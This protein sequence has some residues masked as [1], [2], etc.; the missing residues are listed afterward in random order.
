[1]NVCH[2]IC[3][4]STSN[5]CLKFASIFVLI[6]KAHESFCH[7]LVL[8][9]LCADLLM[10]HVFQENSKPPL[11][12]ELICINLYVQWLLPHL[13]TSSRSTSK[14]RWKDSLY[15]LRWRVELET[16]RSLTVACFRPPTRLTGHAIVCKRNFWRPD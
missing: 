16:P 4:G 15:H 9:C 2:Q 10:V 7:G 8:M 6:R 5:D 3:S 1:M 11:Q 12:Q 13:T 14:E